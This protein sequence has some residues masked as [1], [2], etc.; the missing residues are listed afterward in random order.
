MDRLPR[1]LVC[2]LWL[3]MRLFRSNSVGEGDNWE[4]VGAEERVLLKGMQKSIFGTCNSRTS[5]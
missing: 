5:I 4:G 1:R 3:L 2:K